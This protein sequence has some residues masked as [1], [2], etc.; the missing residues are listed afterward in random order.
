MS[1][2]IEEPAPK[3][4]MRSVSSL[5]EEVE[6][7]DYQAN[8][9]ERE[10]DGGYDELPSDSQVTI[11]PPHPPWDDNSFQDEPY[12]NLYYTFPI[13]DALWLPLDPV[14]AL[15]M[16]ATVTMGVALTSEPGAGHLGPL[17]ER[18]ASARSVLSGLTADLESAIS[19]SGDEVSI[20]GSPL[21]G[22]EEIELAPTATPRAQN[23]DIGDTPTMEQQLNLLRTAWLR[24]TTPPAPQTVMSDVLLISPS[25]LMGSLRTMSGDPLLGAAGAAGGRAYPGYSL[26]DGAHTLTEQRPTHTSP[27]SHLS[28]NQMHSTDSIGRCS[29]LPLPPGGGS[30][31]FAR[32]SRISHMSPHDVVQKALDDEI[33]VIRRS[34]VLLQE[35]AER[36]NAPQSRWTS[37]AFEDLERTTSYNVR[38]HR[39]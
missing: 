9:Q 37:W 19:V 29:L 6:D 18:L 24:P 4:A 22:T 20:S 3:R 31:H 35:E 12:E 26:T 1:P 5:G 8:D 2:I 38:P 28:L 16:D 36:Q 7:G 39:P 32:R 13:K 11:N 21:D 34:H 15:D 25:L 27:S 14:G 30:S 10:G 33:E 17:V 23:E